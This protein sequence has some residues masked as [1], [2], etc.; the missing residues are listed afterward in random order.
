[1]YSVFTRLEEGEVVFVASRDELGHVAQL[2]QELSANWPHEYV[3]R[4]SDGNN[5]DLRSLI[6][7]KEC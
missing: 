5:V 2:V 4:D 7:F 6:G 1:M 3:V